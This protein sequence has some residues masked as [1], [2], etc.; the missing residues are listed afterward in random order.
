M[1]WQNLSVIF[2]CAIHSKVF[3][4]F[5]IAFIIAIICMGGDPVFKEEAE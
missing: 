3:W 1:N 5:V 4:W 2:N